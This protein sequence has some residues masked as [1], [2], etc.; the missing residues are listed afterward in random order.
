MMRR[1]WR[2]AGTLFGCL[3]LLFLVTADAGA[4]RAKAFAP[5]TK[6]IDTD[7]HIDVNNSDCWV[8][9]YGSFAWD[10]GTGNPGYIFPKGTTK[11][12]IFAAGLWMGARVNGQ[13]RVSVAEYSS[14]YAPGRIIGGEAENMESTALR[15]YKLSPGAEDDDSAVWPCDQGAPCN[16]DGTPRQLG[17]M[18]L[19]GVYNDLNPAASTN[20]AASPDPLGVEVRQTTFAFNRTGALGNVIFLKFQVINPPTGNRLDDMYLSVWSDPDLGG[21]SDDLVGCDTTLSLGYCYN[22]NNNDNLYGSNP[23][24]VGFDFFQGPV[25]PSDGDTAYVDGRA[26]PNKKNLPMTSFNKYINGTDPGS[27]EESY[28]YMR[29]L[30]PNGTPV[31]D[32][33][34]NQ[35]TTYF[36]PGDPVAATGWLDS[37]PADRRMMLSSGPFNMEPGDT[38]T[39]VTAIIIGQGKDRLT[40]ITALKFYD[41]F[42]QAAFDANFDLPSPPRRPAV[43]GAQ[44]DD[45]LV[46]YWGKDSETGYDEEGY[47]FEGYNIYQGES[48]AGPWQ[49]IF[50]FDLNNNVGIIFDD[51][52][53]LETGV[54]IN[55]PVQFGADTGVR[56]TLTIGNDYVRGGSLRNGRPYYF[57]V[58]SYSYG[59]DEAAGLLTLENSVE[60]IIL[61]P[62]MPTSGT[63]LLDGAADD[64]LAV[65]KAG[66]SSDGRVIPILRDP[67]RTTGETYEITFAEDDQGPYWDLKTIG[68]GARSVLDRQRNQSGDE[69]YVVADGIYWKVV[70]ALPGFK[71]N[72]RPR[73][74]V[75]EIAGPGGVPVPPDGRGGPGNDLF[76]S[77]GSTGDYVLA[78][79]GGDGSEESAIARFT[80]NEQNNSDWDIIM[81]WGEQPDGKANYGWWA[82]NDGEAGPLPF[83]L[84]HRNPATGEEVRLVTLLATSSTPGVFDYQPEDA[85]LDPYFHYIIT[86]WIYAYT[87]DPNAGT[88]DDFV[89]D[90]QDGVIDGDVTGET[91]HELF[92]RLVIASDPAEGAG[93]LPQ[94][95]TVIQFSTT[96]PNT[97]ADIFRVATKGVAFTQNDLK[98]D[99]SQIRVVP[100]PYYAHSAYEM[101]QFEHVVK[102]TRVPPRCTVRIFNLAG[103]LVRT[104]EKGPENTQNS[105]LEWDLLTERRLPVGSGV[106]IYHIEGK[107]AAGKVLGTT[108]GRVAIFIEKER[109]NTF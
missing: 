18:T 29:G 68:A 11:T 109:L 43:R 90:A 2:R 87:I 106:Y 85:D 59:P 104:L 62:Q 81:R 95:G 8:T 98:A 44:L 26:I 97:P 57:G 42:A 46:L 48:I 49:R 78:V 35:P 10:V 92:A 76:L 47:A 100:N 58:T 19:F 12:A 91:G 105:F 50:T 36:M 52:F 80:R 27:A 7:T 103:D 16:Q 5:H 60:P 15:V 17:D 70:G 88:Y 37:N 34:T 28:N 108:H 72:N 21:S 71:R 99:L 45:K 31:I 56:R 94:D 6:G 74:M 32:P 83:G 38:Q 39:V 63:R 102:F 54:V 30:N 65:V 22:A 77:I 79:G 33:T 13:V 41:L 67:Y 3:A 14:T 4:E 96:K 73:P 93:V 101:N 84:Y 107:D 61:T 69:N 9:N 86:D 40:S 55:K 82:F 25:V 1:G 20:N 75:D 64:T 23:P 51:Q 24:A 66:G 53:D 89:A